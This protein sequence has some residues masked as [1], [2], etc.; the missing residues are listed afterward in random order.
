[1][2]HSSTRI[3]HAQDVNEHQP[4]VLPRLRE[5]LGGKCCGLLN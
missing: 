4:G 5:V 1:M 2:S 3:R